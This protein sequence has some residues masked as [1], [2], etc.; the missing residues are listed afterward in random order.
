MREANH[1]RHNSGSPKLPCGKPSARNSTESCAQS[2]PYGFWR[3]MESHCN[4]RIEKPWMLVRIC[5]P[6]PILSRE[7]RILC[8][9]GKPAAQPRFKEIHRAKRVISVL[10]FLSPFRTWELHVF[11]HAV[12]LAILRRLYLPTG[13]SGI[14]FFFCKILQLLAENIRNL[15]HIGKRRICNT[16][17]ANAHLKVIRR[18]QL[19][20]F[21]AALFRTHKGYVTV[22]FGIAASTFPAGTHFFMV[23]SQP[24]SAAL[25]TLIQLLYRGFRLPKPCT[26]CSGVILTT[27]R[28]CFYISAK[29]STVYSSR[30]PN[31]RPRYCSTISF[32]F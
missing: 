7:A 5:F 21:H 14:S 18:K 30:V 19:V 24:L 6:S 3:G 31:F 16:A 9:L 25:H 15:M 17:I 1:H 28:N 29:Y 27:F 10:P 20:V 4:P 11:L 12:Q 32:A 13:A 22:G 2:C 23:G 8:H 26:N